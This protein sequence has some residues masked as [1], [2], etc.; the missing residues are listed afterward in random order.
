MGSHIV[1][2]VFLV[3]FAGVLSGNFMS[4][5]RAVRTWK[6]EN[7]WLVFSFGSLLIIPVLL[8]VFT[9]PSLGGVY[10]SL[11]A[12]D[13]LV[14]LLFGAGWGIAQVLF[15]VSVVNLG[16]ALG[17]AIVIGLGATFGVLV[18][19]LVQHPEIFH[20]SRGALLLTGVA[21][22]LAGVAVCGWAGRER[23]RAEATA[24]TPR[25]ANY[26]GALALAILCGVLAP[27]M[28]YA[29]AF[30]QNIAHSAERFGAHP[31]SASFAVWLIA[32]AGG[33][34]PNVAYSV[35]LLNRNRSW[36]NFK[37]LWPDAGLSSL[38][39]LMWMGA[40][41][42]YSA[43]AW[44]MGP[45]GTSAGWG[46]FQIFMILAANV[47]GLLLGEWKPAGKR[48]VRILYGGVGLL[49]VATALMSF[50]NR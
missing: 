40:V 15:G 30:G 32:L 9:V 31:V 48:P 38:M 46:L 16:M 18:P 42:L 12:M 29:F 22:M 34:V 28:N 10:S 24:P 17:F 39:A 41:T 19:A 23:E 14:P 4:P 5:L 3:M 2:S 1:F 27:M 25:T 47:S 33:L 37:S 26:G 13:I 20:T 50:A 35:Y 21:A 49:A 6:W 36:G 44:Y 43:A 45:L 11:G 7:S 8:A